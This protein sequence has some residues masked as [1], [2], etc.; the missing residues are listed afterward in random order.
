MFLGGQL[1]KIFQ[2]E[3]S[4]DLRSQ[5]C[6]RCP[7]N[8]WIQFEKLKIRSIQLFV[9]KICT[10][11]IQIEAG[12]KQK[13]TSYRSLHIW[14]R[15]YWIWINYWQK[16]VQTKTNQRAKI[17]L[18][19]IFLCLPEIRLN[20]IK[21]FG[22]RSPIRLEVSKIAMDLFLDSQGQGKKNQIL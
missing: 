13:P 14:A 20:L 22:S 3:V 12:L 10:V 4:L 5:G 8:T 16:F 11:L 7:C 21:N 19:V 2:G 9:F 18:H 1:L 17:K 15:H 6:F